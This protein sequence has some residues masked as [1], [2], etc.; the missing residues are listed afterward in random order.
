MAFV[1]NLVPFFSTAE[2]AVDATLNGVAVRGIFDSAYQLG[3]VGSSGMASTAPVLTLATTDVPSSP[4][5][6]SV[7]VNS[8]SYVVSAHEPDG[9]GVSLLLLERAA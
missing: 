9:T 5:G 6:K 7:V 4:V 2:F 1:E 3:D 8:I